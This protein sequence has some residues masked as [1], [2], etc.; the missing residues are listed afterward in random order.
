MVRAIEQSDPV[1]FAGLEEKVAAHRKHRLRL[2][3][4][5][6]G[7]G[8]LAQPHLDH[9]FLTDHLGETDPG[10][11]VKWQDEFHPIAINP[12]ESCFFAGRKAPLATQGFIPEAVEHLVMST[13][14]SGRHRSAAVFFLHGPW[15][16]PDTDH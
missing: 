1:R 15:P 13:L 7:S 12:E 3:W 11:Q 2:V 9:S 6:S 16:L 8:M 5:K 10:L 4:Y 14:P